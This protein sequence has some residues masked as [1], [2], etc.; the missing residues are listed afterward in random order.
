METQILADCGAGK[1]C[2]KCLKCKKRNNETVKLY[3][4]EAI[5][6]QKFKCDLCNDVFNKNHN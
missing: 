2:R 1:W 4:Y 6:Q 3:Q 5:M